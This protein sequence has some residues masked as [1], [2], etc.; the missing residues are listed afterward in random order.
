MLQTQHCKQ[1]FN[2]SGSRTVPFKTL[3]R[4][5]PFKTLYISSLL[6]PTPLQVRVAIGSNSLNNEKRRKKLQKY[7][8]HSYDAILFSHKK[9]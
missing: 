9:D 4:T 2:K 5:V 6:F 7:K 3:Y 8:G 1:R